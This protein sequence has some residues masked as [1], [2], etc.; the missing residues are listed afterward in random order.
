MEKL[1]QE[2]ALVLDRPNRAEEAELGVFEVERL[3]NVQGAGKYMELTVQAPEEEW[4]IEEVSER[5][6]MLGDMVIGG[7]ATEED[8][9]PGVLFRIDVEEGAEDDGKDV[10]GLGRIFLQLDRPSGPEIRGGY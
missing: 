7:V 4:M 3:V 6:V 5:G 8:A 10:R 2:L 9:V 1:T